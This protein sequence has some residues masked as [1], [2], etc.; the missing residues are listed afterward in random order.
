MTTYVV[1]SSDVESAIRE[2]LLDQ[3]GTAFSGKIIGVMAV[4]VGSYNRTESVEMIDAVIEALGQELSDYSPVDAFVDQFVRLVEAGIDPKKERA[5]LEYFPQEEAIVVT[6]V[7]RPAPKPSIKIKDEYHHAQ[8]QGDFYPE[9]LR[10]AFEEL[11]S[12]GI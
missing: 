12:S 8:A 4:M 11:I 1:A 5:D 10:R 2:M 3:L 7:K 9:R 6:P